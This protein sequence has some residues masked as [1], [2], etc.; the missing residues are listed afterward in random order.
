[1][2]TSPSEHLV[3]AAS[4][5]DPQA[6]RQ[7]G[8]DDLSLMLMDAR[9]RTLRWLAAFEA[10]GRLLGGDGHAVVPLRWIGHAA[11]FQ[12][13]WIARNVQRLRGE[14]ADALAP[15]LPSVEARADCWFSPERPPD[16][17]DGLGPGAQEVRDFMAHTLDLSLDLLAQT[18]QTDEGL[19]AF[20]LALLHED[21]L[22]ERLAVAAQ[23]LGFRPDDA[24]LALPSSPPLRPQRA[25]LWMPASTVELGSRPQGLV[26]PNE[27]WAH[28]VQ[29]PDT[30]I[31]AQVVSW[32]RYAEFVQDGGYDEASWWTPEG[33]RWLQ[34]VG[35]RGPRGV[36]QLREGVVLERWGRLGRSAPGL[37]AAHVT[38]HEARAWCAWAG[39]RLPTE[40]EWEMAALTAASRGFV[41]GDVHEW[42]LGGARAY[43]GGDGPPVAGFAEALHEPSADPGQRVLRGASCWT[44]PRAAHLKGRRFVSGFRDD[45]F[46]GF[47]SCA[48]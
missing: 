12:E 4:L 34:T 39:R 1:M 23:W 19:H 18:P 36:E 27:R 10:T 9:N 47:R 48:L 26:P 16:W 24:M 32:A 44:V 29:V 7:A 28:P 14:A 13:Y 22:A 41:W 20:R 30:E 33:W 2:R 17:R 46:C 35:R 45:L 42:M 8:R 40:A 5:N 11:W 38:W 43:P 25:P 31:D 6:A 21:R 3:R 15:R 37:P